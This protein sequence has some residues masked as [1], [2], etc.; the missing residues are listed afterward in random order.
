[1]KKDAQLDL[2]A[3]APADPNVGWLERTLLESREW[4]RAAALAKASGG[5]LDDRDVRALAA[6]SPAVISGQCGYKH[7]ACAT[8]EEISRFVAWMESQGKLMIAR[9]ERVRRQ[10]HGRIG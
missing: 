2:F 8:A 6:A 5:R 7:L 3:A 9:A 4:C 1:M 10:A